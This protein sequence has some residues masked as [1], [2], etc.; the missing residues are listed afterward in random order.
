MLWFVFCKKKLQIPED[1]LSEQQMACCFIQ[2]W[3]QS[4]ADKA[5]S[6]KYSMVFCVISSEGDIMPPH[7]FP[8]A[9]S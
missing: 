4:H 9:S 7:F 6:D 1:Q 8:E 3:D 2:R 5:S